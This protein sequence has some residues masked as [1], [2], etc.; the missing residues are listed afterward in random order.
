MFCEGS[1]V[2]WSDWVIFS[3]DGSTPLLFYLYNICGPDDAYSYFASDSVTAW[4]EGL[5]ENRYYFVSEVEINGDSSV[6][7]TEASTEAPE[8]STVAPEESTVAPEVTTM[9]PAGSRNIF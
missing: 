4:V 5:P 3:S 7:S 6:T 1:N 8:E 9:V 2:E